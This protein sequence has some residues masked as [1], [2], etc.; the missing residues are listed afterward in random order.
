M[1]SIWN[2]NQ[3]APR[4]NNLP[5]KNND[6]WTEGRSD[7]DLDSSTIDPILAWKAHSGRWIADAK[8][9][10]DNNYSTSPQRLL[11]AGNDGTI[12]LWDLCRLC[13]NDIP[14]LLIQSD[15]GWHSSGIFCLD[16]DNTTESTMICTS[17]KDKTIA[18]STMEAFCGGNSVPHWRS[19]FHSAKVGAVQLK[20][21]QRYVLASAS[22]DG[23]VAIHDYRV[24]GGSNKTSV[25]AKLEYAHP[26]PHSVVWDPM[27][28]NFL[29]TAGM[30]PFI[31]LWDW[32]NLS[33]PLAT[34]E[35]HVPVGR[36]CK[37]IHRPVF[38][39][40]TNSQKNY[41]LSGGGGSSALSTFQLSYVNP[42]DNVNGNV[43]TTLLSRGVLPE[44][45]GDAGCIAVHGGLVAASVNQG[46]ILLLQPTS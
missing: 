43:Q 36:P 23:L 45:C 6:D 19:Q 15:K 16:V 20:K 9:L 29:L 38:I 2:I 37:K 12:C 34:M 22:D 7:S 44:D 13:K 27:E 41:I 28:E 3:S 26:R 18:V 35:G 1:I 8:F 4:C 46:D 25:V 10:A 5:E 30:D 14:K 40:L 11:S 17:S 33:Q 32:R 21:S 42:M 39:P 31:K 24:H